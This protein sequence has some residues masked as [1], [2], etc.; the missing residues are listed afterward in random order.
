MKS[1]KNYVR[2]YNKGG[3]VV[4]PMPSSDVR[5]VPTNHLSSRERDI[6]VKQATNTTHMKKIVI[7]SFMIVTT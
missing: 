5:G 6:Q 7:D 1:W 4:L 2:R 3:L